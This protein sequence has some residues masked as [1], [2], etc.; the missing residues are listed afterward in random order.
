MI[1]FT[2]FFKNRASNKCL[3]RAV[4]GNLMPLNKKGKSH[5]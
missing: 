5:L 3:S 1:L 2:W 4:I